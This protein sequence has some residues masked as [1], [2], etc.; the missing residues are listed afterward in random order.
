MLLGCF[1]T[2]N[3]TEISDTII[4][5]CQIVYLVPVKKKDSAVKMST[6]KATIEHLKK[7]EELKVKDFKFR[8][9]LTK[10]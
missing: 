9:F 4:I 6:G 2:I 5:L 1:K 8:P 7:L 3:H 10:M